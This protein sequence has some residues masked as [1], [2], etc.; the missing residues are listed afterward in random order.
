MARYGLG[1][2]LSALHGKRRGCSRPSDKWKSHVGIS[3]SALSAIA[4]I[5]KGREQPMPES[6]IADRRLTWFLP[7]S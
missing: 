5:E 1:L 7:Q 2:V 4:G 3:R 6:C